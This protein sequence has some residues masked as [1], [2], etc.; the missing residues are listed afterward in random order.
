MA[1]AVKDQLWRLIHSLSK[2]EKR[3]FK[4]YATRAGSTVD[5][6]F[7]QLFDVLDRLPEPNDDQAMARMKITSGQYS[8]LKRHLYQQLLTS[9][10]LI[11]IDK[12]IDIEL[13]EQL[14]FARILYGKG[15][16]LDALRILERAK[17]KAVEHN[18]DLLHLEIL[19][20]QK[21]IEARH[22]TLSRQDEDKL[23]YLVN[24]SAERSFS[25]L[26]TSEL[27]NINIQIHGRYIENGHS[28]GPEDELVNREF[29]KSI[30]R[31]HIDRDSVAH[32]FH[33]KINRFQAAMW[34][35]YIQ[36]QLDDALES[37]R[38]AIA[39]F[40]ISR[41][42]VM[43][44]PDLY[45]RALYYVT[46]F[47]YLNRDE[48]MVARYLR[49]MEDFLSNE[50]I[51]LNENSQLIGHTYQYLSQFNHHFLR[52]DGAAAYALSLEVTAAYTEGRFLP[53]EQR[54]GLFRYKCAAACFLTHR[55]GEALDHL[56]EI[57][58]LR[59]GILR[60]DLLINSR[61]LHAIC[62]FE[63]GNLALVDYHLTGL[64]RLLRKS[65]EAAEVHRLAI[66][67][68]RRL[69]KCPPNEHLPIYQQLARDLD[70][71]T[72]HPFEQKALVYLNLQDW[73]NLHTPA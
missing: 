19:E 33:Q 47:A 8:N 14:D 73:L 30:Q 18:Q 1:T 27:F 58:N 9:L 32:T 46:L 16:Y 59:S 17:A 66:S 61:I 50:N 11:Y 35:N 6:K 53:N 56:N 20:F 57:I 60:E 63:I 52:R 64:S 34:Y 49:R 37:A 21:L 23:E 44:D 31:G 70:Q 67:T 25:V 48:K 65:R 69:L 29:W 45:L 40:E 41:H 71:P 68:L 22:I 3:S 15:H 36:L 38:N 28:R 12:E 4:L 42:M 7:I 26:N 39:L 24:E 2:A 43:K 5:S 51:L 54:W 62:H 72:R 13:R 10:R 55:F